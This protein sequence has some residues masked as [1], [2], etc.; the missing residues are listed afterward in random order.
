MEPEA[1]YGQEHLVE[2]LR[3][4]D[5]LVKP[6]HAIVIPKVDDEVWVR[7]ANTHGRQEVLQKSDYVATLY[8]DVC[9]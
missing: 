6:A 3:S 2:P 5:A 4:Y 1:Y 8:P 7:A 9:I